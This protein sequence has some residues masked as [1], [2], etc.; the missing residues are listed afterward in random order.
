MLGKTQTSLRQ[1]L[2]FQTRMIEIDHWITRLL[3]HATAATFFAS[4][5]FNIWTFLH[6]STR[7]CHGSPCSQTVALQPT[8]ETPDF[9][10]PQP[11][12]Y[13]PPNSPDLSQSGWLYAIWGILQQ[14]VYSGMY[15]ITE[16]EWSTIW[17]NDW[18]V[19][20]AALISISLT[21]QSASGD[22]VCIAV[23]AR[24]ADTLNIR[25]K[26]CHC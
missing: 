16:V 10:G 5:S 4:H 21:E 6:V 1:S 3:E 13:W 20:G 22:S 2:E 11:P 9:V 26:H 7:Q 19:Y 17:K 8:A 25:F 15:R 12:Q 24:K 14:R 18:F 23:S